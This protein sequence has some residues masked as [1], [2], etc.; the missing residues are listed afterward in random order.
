LGSIVPTASDRANGTNQQPAKADFS[1]PQL[2][3]RHFSSSNIHR[4]D[5]CNRR[6]CNVNRDGQK[7]MA[8]YI[9][10]VVHTKLLY[11]VNEVCSQ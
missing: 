5:N 4:V 1:K 8:A 7:A 11:Q 6:G 2:G 3:C 9:A 10:Y